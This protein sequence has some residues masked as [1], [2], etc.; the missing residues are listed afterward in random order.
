MTAGDDCS[1][2]AVGA[3]SIGGSEP[4]QDSLQD[5]PPESLPPNMTAGDD[6]SSGALDNFWSSL[7][8]PLMGSIERPEP[9]PEPLDEDSI[10]AAQFPVLEE[11]DTSFKAMSAADFNACDVGCG[12]S[13]EGSIGASGEGSIERPEEDDPDSAHRPVPGSSWAEASDQDDPASSSW[14]EASDPGSSPGHGS[15]VVEASD[16]DGGESGIVSWPD[17]GDVEEAVE[18]AFGTTAASAFGNSLST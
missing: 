15:W 11:D 18:E 3:D 17:A 2:G 16:A 12:A 13:D 6:S 14:V 8:A 10:A 7:F 1:I 5:S 4:L 9:L